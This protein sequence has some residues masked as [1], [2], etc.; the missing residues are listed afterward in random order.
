MAVDPNARPP[1]RTPPSYRPPWKTP[2]FGG[3]T[4]DRAPFES[5][6]SRGSLRQSMGRYG[7]YTPKYPGAGRYGGLWGMA[8]VFI[9]GK[10]IERIFEMQDE[11]I[12]AQLEAQNAQIEEKLR[13]RAKEKVLRTTSM[14]DPAGATVPTVPAP[15]SA[16]GPEVLPVPTSR[17]ELPAD[18]PIEIEFPQPGPIIPTPGPV[19]PTVPTPTPGQAPATTPGISPTPW[20]IEIPSTVTTPVFNPSAQ[21]KP[22]PLTS[23]YG[24][25][26]GQPGTWPFQTP[27]PGWVGDP[28]PLSFSQRP[29]D[30][31]SLTE[32]DPRV[33]EFPQPAAQPQP[34][35]AR[36]C[37]PCKEDNPQPREACYKGLYRE[38]RMDTDVDFVE[39]AEINCETGVEI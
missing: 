1:P 27:R 6:R 15:D 21:P 11:E 26:W 38:G 7:R 33:I 18:D 35:Q 13:R 24:N 28:Q 34:D 2:G 10:I 4:S 14:S 36:R 25:P 30:P 9:F 23:P 31:R 19:T 8:G 12:D 17:I 16:A 32:I 22:K 20:P 29:S 5:A 39:W 37:K 3:F